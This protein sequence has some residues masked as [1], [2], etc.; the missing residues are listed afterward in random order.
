MSYGTITQSPEEL[1]QSLL[2]Q[3]TNIFKTTAALKVMVGERKTLNE[4]KER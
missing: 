2:R 1:R 4:Q 3:T